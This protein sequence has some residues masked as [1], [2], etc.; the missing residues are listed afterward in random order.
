MKR[1]GPSGAGRFTGISLGGIHIWSN[2]PQMSRPRDSL[3]RCVFT[4]VRPGMPTLIGPVVSSH[5]FDSQK[6]KVRGSN[7]RVMAYADMKMLLGCSN[8]P[9]GAGPIFP[10]WNIWYMCHIQYTKHISRERER[11]CRTILSSTSEIGRA[12]KPQTKDLD[13]RGFDSSWFLICKGWNSQVHGE[14]PRKLDSAILGLRILTLQI[15]S[16]GV[17]CNV[18]M[19]VYI[20]IYIYRERERD[21]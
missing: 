2:C 8:L 4:K 10:D 15:G 11:S 5:D 19:Y 9:L 13:F 17:I 7:A 18:Y 21:R 12:A 20:Y 6:F 3:T 14:L 1:L 16:K